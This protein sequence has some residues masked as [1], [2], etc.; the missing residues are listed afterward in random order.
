M[1]NDFG[2]GRLARYARGSLK[3]LADRDLLDAFDFLAEEAF[4][5]AGEL[6]GK[7]G[8]ANGDLGGVRS[9]G[10]SEAVAGEFAGEGGGGVAAC[11]ESTSTTS[12]PRT[13]WAI[14]FRSG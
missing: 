1:T 14:G 10:A 13:R 2:R 11:A 9:G 12:G 8:G 5:E 3:E 7:I 4:G 6:G